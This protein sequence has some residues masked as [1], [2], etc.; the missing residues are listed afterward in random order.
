MEQKI[1]IAIIGGTGKS[2]KY[3]VKQLIDN[4]FSLK[5]LLRNPEKFQIKSSCIE[6]VKGDARFYDSIRLLINGCQAVI[7]TLGQPKGE[8]PIFKEATENV[9][10]VMEELNIQR[11]ILVSGLNVDTPFDQKGPKTKIATDWMCTNFPEATRDRQSEYGLLS[12]SDLN[13]TLVRIPLIEQTDERY[14]MEV[15]LTDCPGDRISTVDLAQFLI[16]QL[17]DD[18]YIKKSPFI[19]NV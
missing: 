13:W 9:I 19:A 10:R 7:S 11:Y 18:S 1:K 14:N 3:L 2:G 8:L 16:K 5:L 17:T 4:N 12:K 6:T 15:S